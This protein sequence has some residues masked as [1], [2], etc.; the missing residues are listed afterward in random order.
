MGEM[1]SFILQEGKCKL[2]NGL[3]SFNKLI[4]H[5][6]NNYKSYSNYLTMITPFGSHFTA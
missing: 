4:I 5:P 6:H 3:K 1:A 2:E